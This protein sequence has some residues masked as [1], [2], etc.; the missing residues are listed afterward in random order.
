MNS[1]IL[2]RR[3]FIFGAICLVTPPAIVRVSSLMPVKPYR[4]RL[5]ERY[6][7][8]RGLDIILDDEAC[9]RYAEEMARKGI[10]VAF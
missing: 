1:L 8:I 9:R 3:R 2:P 4:L 6:P 5:W 7:P 10:A